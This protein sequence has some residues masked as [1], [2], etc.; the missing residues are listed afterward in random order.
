VID[1]LIPTRPVTLVFAIAGLALLGACSGSDEQELTEW[2]AEQRRNTPPKVVDVPAPKKFVPQAFTAS[3]TADPYNSQRLTA[4]LRREFKPL[5]DTSALVKPELARQAVLKQPLESVGLE[6]M[7]YVGQLI[8][9]G[10]PVA[11]LRVNGLIYQVRPGDYLGQNFGRITR[12]SDAEISLR[13][14]VQDTEGEWSER[15]AALAAVTASANAARGA[16]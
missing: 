7:Q 9:D 16:K 15:K 6:A 12:I 13:E 14:I 5:V 4:A 10:R 1:A 3:E 2:M 8:K 11:L